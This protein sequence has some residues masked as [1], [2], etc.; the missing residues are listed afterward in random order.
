MTLDDIKTWIQTVVKAPDG[1]YFTGKIDSSKDNCIGIY[2]A[3]PIKP[4]IAIGGIQNTSYAVKCVGILIHWGKYMPAAERKAQEVFDVLFSNPK[5]AII[6]GHRVID[7]SMRFNQPVSLDT[8]D[9]CIYEYV[10]YTNIYYQ[11]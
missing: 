5:N 4:H 11:K 7:F 9:N 10:V 8:D 6:G 1:C 3:E 2:D